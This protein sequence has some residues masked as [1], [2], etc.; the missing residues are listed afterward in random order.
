M[1]AINARNHQRKNSSRKKKVPGK[2]KPQRK[3]NYVKITKEEYQE[4]FGRKP[5]EN[6]FKD[7]SQTAKT[8]IKGD[9]LTLN[10]NLSKAHHLKTLH[11]KIDW[12]GVDTDLGEKWETESYHKKNGGYFEY[13]ENLH[14][15]IIDETLKDEKSSKKPVAILM[16]G[17]GASGKGTILNREIL[18]KYDKPVIDPD[19]IKSKLPE[20]E[21]FQKENSKTMSTRLHRESSNV[22]KQA[23]YTAISEKKSFIYDGTMRDEKKYS[24][25]IKDLKKNGYKVKAAVVYVDFD[26]AVKRAEERGKKT[27]RFVPLEALQDS[28]TRVTKTFAKLKPQFDSYTIYDNTTRKTQIIAKNGKVNNPELYK[29]YQ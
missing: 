10:T 20:K 27:G 23:I 13:R 6:Q 25:I 18:P 7:T 17:G 9:D 21:F 8:V 26:E 12:Y 2:S 1:R 19:E 22:T 29:R 15:K 5:I 4:K 16:G 14:E 28:H 11:A 3:M 24:E